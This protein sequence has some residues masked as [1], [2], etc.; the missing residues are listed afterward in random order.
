MIQ[1]TEKY[2][3]FKKQ[4]CNRD[5]QEN[6]VK[7]LMA[8]IKQENL[9]YLEPILVNKQFE[10]IDG[11][12]RLEA[13]KRLQVEIYYRVD[14]NLSESSIA[15]LNNNTL[16]WKYND[17]LNY[18]NNTG[19][20]HYHKLDQ[21]A[22]KNSIHLTIAL[23]ML[24]VTHG[25]NSMRSF[26]RGMFKFPDAQDELEAINKLANLRQM[27][28]YVCTKTIG[29]KKYLN[30][31]L[32]SRSFTAFLNVKSVD[33]NIFMKKLPFKLDLLRPCSRIIHYLEIFR[34]IY[35]FKNQQPLNNE[36]LKEVYSEK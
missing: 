8:S 24:G 1:S 11:Q 10:V 29:E 18:Y 2:S 32:F 30:G 16:R 26:K 23:A 25:G 28:E 17:W 7:H 35:N 36:D 27:I 22:K 15:L 20:I 13:A 12:H 34:E 19:N 6:H 9:L 3:M 14:D 21:F 5:I 4:H 33:F 31:P